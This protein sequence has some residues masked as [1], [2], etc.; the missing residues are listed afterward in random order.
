[1]EKMEKLQNGKSAKWQNIEMAKW[2]KGK[3]MV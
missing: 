2:Q 1:M 3:K